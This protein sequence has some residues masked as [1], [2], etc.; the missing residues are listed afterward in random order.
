M[1]LIACPECK[2]EMSEQAAACPHC[3]HPSAARP[4]ATRAPKGPKVVQLIGAVLFATGVVSCATN[5][6]PDFFFV[7]STTAA[8]LTIFLTG[9]LVDWWGGHG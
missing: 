6:L 9:R 5:P 4:V 8:G 2:K 7:A 3:G 1:T